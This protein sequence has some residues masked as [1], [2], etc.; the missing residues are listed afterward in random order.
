MEEKN[1]KIDI[2][3]AILVKDVH[4][5]RKY[6]DE[7]SLN[8]ILFELEQLNDLEVV[9]FFR[10]LKTDV[11][12]ELFSH[13]PEE[14]Q[15]IIVKNLTKK[16]ITEIVNELY[17]D[18][19]ADLLEALP[20]DMAKTI[21]LTVDKET[22][23]KVNEL[24]Q[25]SDDEVGSV[26]SVDMI[27]LN[28][29]L[30]NKEALFLIKKKREEA[31]IGK[32]F[33]IVDKK[34]KLLGATTLEDL[35]FNP[36]DSLIKEN[37]IKATSI[38]TKQTK[39]QAAIIFAN[40]DRSIL[41]VVNDEDVV[42]G[43]LT[44]DDVIDIIHEEAT[45]DFYKASGISL[46]QTTTSY[47][48]SSVWSLVR[49]R[50]FWLIILMIGSTLSQVII[51]FFSKSFESEILKTGLSSAVMIALIPVTS[52]TSGNAGSQ[53]TSTLTRAL[54][55]GELRDDKM[56]RIIWKE[57]LV[58][59]ILGSILAIVNYLRLTIYYTI[60][61]DLINDKTRI[62]VLLISL[63]SSISLLF[64]ITLSKLLGTTIL[65]LGVKFKKDPTV[66]A[67]PLLT[68]LID[69]LSTLIFFSFSFI[70]LIPTVMQIFIN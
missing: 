36:K 27:L 23:I 50:V 18:E 43:I 28:E 30:T 45:E 20:S 65:I 1:T 52:A 14:L 32:Y 35:I 29:E 60:T 39:E 15:Q 57:F 68:T 6:V 58:G 11:A 37:M 40:E 13:L 49:S 33:Y 12:G 54:A 62:F 66:M 53:S 10:F 2:K 69:G 31:E 46:N 38:K 70:L 67:T 22:R 26:M 21:L 47:L 16:E 25:F 41:P 44:A 7:S 56:S 51:Q 61:Q 64:S 9:L 42:L 4:T 3:Y 17:T 63:V 5:I 8:D 55:L 48:K 24:L 34:N 19:V 59:L